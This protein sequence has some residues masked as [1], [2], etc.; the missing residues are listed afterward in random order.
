MMKRLNVV[1]PFADKEC[2]ELNYQADEMT[3]RMMDNIVIV[4][5]RREA[6]SCQREGIS[7]EQEERDKEDS[8]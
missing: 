2:K 3:K 4:F 8:V 1:I 5:E 7:C 6:G